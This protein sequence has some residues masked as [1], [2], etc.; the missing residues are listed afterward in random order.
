MHPLSANTSVKRELPPLLPLRAFESAARNLSFTL[1]AD[2]L[3]VTQSAISRHIKNLEAHF[4]L[5]LFNRLTR[6]IELTEAGQRLYRVVEKSFSDIEVV[7]RALGE[8]ASKQSLVVSI[9]PTLASTWLMPRLTR[10]TQLHQNVEVR[11]HT[12]IA[13][14]A[15]DRDGIDVAIRVGKPPSMRRRKGAPRIDL[16]MTADW[17]GVSAERLFPDVLVP[18]CLPTLFPKGMPVDPP[19]LTALPLIHT[20]SR[21]HAWEDWFAAQNIPYTPATRDLHFGHFFMSVRAALEGRGV[22]LVPDIL[23]AEHVASGELAVPCDARIS[24]GGDYCLLYR[25]ERADEDAIASFRKWI[26]SESAAIRLHAGEL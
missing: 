7:S 5:K 1:A 20:D 21:A 26:V 23:V 13:P 24:S 14:V 25:K 4:Q 12:S 19:L 16:V 15:F 3:C 17:R 22:A 2:E 6:E 8:R 10:Y 11:L 9:L 18:V